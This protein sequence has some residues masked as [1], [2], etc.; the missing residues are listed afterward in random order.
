MKTPESFKNVEHYKYL[1][2]IVI[3]LDDDSNNSKVPILNILLM[4]N[5]YF[6]SL[7]A[8][9]GPFLSYTVLMSIA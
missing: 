4:T 9:I 3:D 6:T 5:V 1:S 2:K 8:K 7:P